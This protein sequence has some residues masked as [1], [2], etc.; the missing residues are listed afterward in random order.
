[1]NDTL[2]ITPEEV[3]TLSPLRL[4][5]PGSCPTVIAY[6]AD[7]LPEMRRQSDAYAAARAAAGRPTRML[8]IAG[9]DHFSVLDA[10]MDPAGALALAAADLAGLR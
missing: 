8:P 3:D 9:A 2:R 7:E 4:I 5:G 6:G 10:M 1:M